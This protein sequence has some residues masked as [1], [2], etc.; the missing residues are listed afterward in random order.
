M[1]MAIHFEGLI[2]RGEVRDSADVAR[3]GQLTRARVTQSMG[4]LHLAPDNREELLFL[5]RT[6]EG[7]DPVTE[8]DLRVV[9]A[10]VGWK[11]QRGLRLKASPERG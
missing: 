4:L 7:N 9:A 2:R 1:A 6:I 8:R 11:T 5:P 3:L 10:A